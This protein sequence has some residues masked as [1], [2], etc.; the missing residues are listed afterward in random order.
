MPSAGRAALSSGWGREPGGGEVGR[1][2]FAGSLWEL[3]GG[4][5]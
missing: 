5:C 4:T 1:E 3:V 2:G